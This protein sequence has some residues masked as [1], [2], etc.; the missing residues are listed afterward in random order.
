[1]PLNVGSE[2]EHHLPKARY[3]FFTLIY[4][5]SMWDRAMKI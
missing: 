5:S 1:M 2:T 3:L 4:D